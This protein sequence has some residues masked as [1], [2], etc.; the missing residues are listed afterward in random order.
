MCE[1]YDVSPRGYY[2]WKTRGLSSH[3][4][5]DIELF[6]GIERIFGD[7]D[8][9]YGSPKMYEALKQEGYIVGENRVARL[10]RENGL[11]AR[12]ASIYRS[13][14]KMDRFY[15]SIANEIYDLEATAPD[16]IWVGDVTYLRANNEWRYLAVILDKFSRRVVG[17]SLSHRRNVDLSLKAFK[18][19]A[20]KYQNWL[21]DNGVTQSMNRKGIMNDNAE[22]E[23]FFH[24]FKAERIHKNEFITEKELRAV[25]IEYVGFYNQKR[26]H[27]SLEYMTPNEYEARM[28]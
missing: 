26:I 17:W 1:V 10:M 2:S 16:Q 25:I 28:A 24:S 4:K 13:H 21:K 20:K 9:V 7:V 23:S 12:C 3:A 8:G 15:A 22:M 14:A 11:K 19:A 5:N 6:A 18:Q 27:S